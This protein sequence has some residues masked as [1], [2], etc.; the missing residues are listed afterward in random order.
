MRNAYME[1][2]EAKKLKQKQRDRMSAKTGKMDIAYEVS[3][4]AHDRRRGTAAALPMLV[5]CCTVPAS[6]ACQ[7]G[8]TGQ[9]L[10][11][12]VCGSALLCRSWDGLHALQLHV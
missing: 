9:Q 6:P 10:A 5:S 7:P 1:K 3:V 11:S 8:R 2:E 4:A 12:H